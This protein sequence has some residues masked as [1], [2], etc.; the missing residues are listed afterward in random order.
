MKIVKAPENSGL[1]VKDASE[2]IE[3]EA[4]EQKSMLLSMLS[5]K[6]FKYAIRYFR[7]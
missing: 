1:K 5:I 7:R 4:K 6:I 2:T 3:N